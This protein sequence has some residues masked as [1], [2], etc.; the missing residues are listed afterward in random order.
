MGSDVQGGIH[1]RL[2][3]SE[4]HRPKGNDEPTVPEFAGKVRNPLELTAHLGDQLP[5]AVID[6]LPCSAMQLA[7][8]NC[9]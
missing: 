1:D 7:C 9:R 2:V 6:E 8:F 3:A 5:E 4:L